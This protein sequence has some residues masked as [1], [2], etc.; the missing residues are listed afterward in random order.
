MSKATF[1]FDDP[2]LYLPPLALVECSNQ[3]NFAYVL[4]AFPGQRDILEDAKL[5]AIQNCDSK[6]P[7]LQGRIKCPNPHNPLL[8]PLRWTAWNASY[9]FWMKHHRSLGRI[10]E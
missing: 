4:N 6:S 2:Q 10:G 7:A 8:N 1:D 9:S 5:T 3:E